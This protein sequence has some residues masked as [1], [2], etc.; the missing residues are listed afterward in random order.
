MDI[1]QKLIVQHNLEIGTFKFY[2]NIMLGEINEGM[3]VDFNSTL[4]P[5]QLCHQIY[6]QAPIIYISNRIN[7]YSIDPVSFYEA[8]QIIPNLIGFAIVT[9]NQRRQTLACLEK[10]FMQK[11]ID[12]FAEMADAF[13]WGTNLLKHEIIHNKNNNLKSS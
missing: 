1:P 12:V 3:H 7:S 5:I 4:V 2:K 9:Q 11:P 13:T 8:I 6:K 10:L